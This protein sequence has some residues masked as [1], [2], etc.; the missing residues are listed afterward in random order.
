MCLPSSRLLSSEQAIYLC[1]SAPPE[2]FSQCFTVSDA[3]KCLFLSKK[4]QFTYQ[5]HVP[6]KAMPAERIILTYFHSIE[7][8]TTL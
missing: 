5:G 8:Y 3:Q 1:I 6:I 4:F 2:P 7:S